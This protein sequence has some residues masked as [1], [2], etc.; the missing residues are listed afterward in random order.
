VVPD[1]TVDY[2]ILDRSLLKSDLDRYEQFYIS[3]CGPSIKKFVGAL[4]NKMD[5]QLH[6]HPRAI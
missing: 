1:A 6:G 5:I 2:E 4:S 3:T